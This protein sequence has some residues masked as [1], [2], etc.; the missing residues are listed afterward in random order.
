MVLGKEE[1]DLMDS[2]D[3][4][5]RIDVHEQRIRQARVRER[6]RGLKLERQLL[7]DM[8][9]EGGS[10]SHWQWTAGH[11]FR[12]DRLAY[13][14]ARARGHV[15]KSLP[16]DARPRKAVGY[17]MQTKGIERA[18]QII[19]HRLT[20]QY[21]EWALGLIGEKM[22]RVEIAQAQNVTVELAEFY[23]VRPPRVTCGTR[24]K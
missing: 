13:L 8:Y 23:G 3:Y 1:A 4:A 17:N 16:D 9:F 2:Y 7:L 22:I 20:P 11:L 19:N 24:E 6:I 5:P 21:L 15:R 18:N 10:L 12:E 14:E